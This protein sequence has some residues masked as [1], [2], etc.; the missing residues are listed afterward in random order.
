[1]QTYI[2][3]R[4]AFGWDWL[5]LIAY[6]SQ[7][8]I[9]NRAIRAVANRVLL[10]ALKYRYG[11]GNENIEVDRNNSAA[12][13]L[14]DFGIVKLE[15]ALSPE[16]CKDIR[17]HLRKKTLVDSRGSGLSF[18]LDQIP[19][20]CRFGDYA[21]ETVVNC[22]HV[23]QVANNPQLVGLAK[24]TLGFAPTIT[25]LSLR[26]TFPNASEPDAV[27]SFHRDCEVGSIKILIYLTDVDFQT[28]PHTYIKG[29][30]NDRIPIRLKVSPD[31]EVNRMYKSSLTI[32][33]PAGTTLAIDT[34]GLHK[35]AKPVTKPRLLLGI[36]Y[37]LLPCYIF[38]YAPIRYCGSEKLDKYMNRL[39]IKST[40]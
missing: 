18:T 13:I 22:P 3:L 30:H 14:K 34:K 8:L 9:T 24:A 2:S 20:G 21:F 23:L 29:S 16:Q 15:D 26:W 6:Y 5:R 33:G 40:A 25:G 12:S 11:N 27:Q 28:G 1:M 37:S 38:R 36:Q 4:S 31:A 17:L 7:R 32:L 10:R 19:K 35:G 39:M